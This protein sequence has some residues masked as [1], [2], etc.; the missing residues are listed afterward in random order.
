MESVVNEEEG[1]S[2]VIRWLL[3]T[4]PHINTWGEGIM[5]IVAKSRKWGNVYSPNTLSITIKHH[6]NS[7]ELEM[8]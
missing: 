3:D 2:H 6:G 5:V 4:P 7:S 8:I 1:R